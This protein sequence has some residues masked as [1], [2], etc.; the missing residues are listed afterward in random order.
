M[1]QRQGFY[2][3]MRPVVRERALDAAAEL[4]CADGGWSAVTMGRV[5]ERVGVSRQLVYKELGGKAALAEALVARE[6]E[7]VLSGV[8]ERLRAHRPDALAGVLAAAEFV[9]RTAEDNPLVKALVLA[10]HGG[11][12]GLLPLLTTRPGPV[13][14]LATKVLFAEARVRY[15]ALAVDDDVLRRIVEIV[16]RLTLS[17]LL[18]P[19]G[20]IEEAVAQ[21]STVLE[22]TLAHYAHDT[23]RCRQGSGRGTLP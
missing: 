23:R 4:I 14:G 21:L 10:A 1:S 5:A 18:R 22:A 2:A 3:A 8:L 16:V 9:L 15:A 7:R 6:T 12:D 20:T 11:D 17:H 19:S 13:L